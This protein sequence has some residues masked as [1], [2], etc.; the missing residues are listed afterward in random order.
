MI[1]SGLT[2]TQSNDV[3]LICNYIVQ[4]YGRDLRVYSHVFLMNSIAFRIAE[5]GASSAVEYVELLKS[6]ASEINRLFNSMNIPY[7]VFFRNM[8]DFS[9]IEQFVLPELFNHHLADKAPMVR[10][11]S[12]GCATGQES[13]SLMMLA[14]KFRQKHPR[15]SPAIVFGTDIS[16]ESLALAATGKFDARCIQNVRLSQLDEYFTYT[17]N[18][19]TVKSEL[20]CGVEFSRYDM[21]DANTS[22][23][24]SGIFGG[25]DMI[26]CCNLLIY[27]KPEIQQAIINKLFRA[28]RPKGFLM[29]DASERALL[30][31]HQGF[32]A[33]SNVS[34]LFVKL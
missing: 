34:N 33:Y 2:D 28:L 13:Y 18:S 32:I 27:Y 29:V 8:I 14:D 4:E 1:N 30:R 16:D 24:P 19:Y 31:Q 25:F 7:S 9:I 10:I 22:S 6:D 26:C 3:E 11:W 23:P 12:A 5:T 20:K 21:L 15:S 17:E